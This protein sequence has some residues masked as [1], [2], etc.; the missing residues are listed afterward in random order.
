[1][2]QVIFLFLLVE[3]P[4][5][6]AHLVHRVVRGKDYRRAGRGLYWCAGVMLIILGSFLFAG[7]A[8]LHNS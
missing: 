7:V 3:I 1:M 5:D 4:I 6:L 2:I 8:A